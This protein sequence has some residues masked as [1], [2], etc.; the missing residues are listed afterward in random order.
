MHPH[1][2]DAG[3]QAASAPTHLPQQ[4]SHLRHLLVLTLSWCT[5]KPPLMNPI[6]HFDGQLYKENQCRATETHSKQMSPYLHNARR[7]TT[8]ATA[9]L[10][11][12]LSHLR[13]LL[14]L[15][16][17]CR[18]HDHLHELLLV[19][20]DL[21]HET[22]VLLAQLLQLWSTTAQKKAYTE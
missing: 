14:V 19:R 9:H 10:S 5:Q 17:S 7:Q 20:A 6:K 12:Q 13:H 18:L 22:G 4:L 15:T 3:G 16:L 1:L 8:S 2:H 21:L 11:Q